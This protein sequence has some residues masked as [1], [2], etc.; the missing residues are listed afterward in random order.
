MINF[1]FSLANPWSNRWSILFFKN[2]L[3]PNHKAWEFNGYLT[4]HIVDVRF[5]LSFTGDHPGL[6][7]MLG[8]VGCSLEFSV[9]DTRHG[10]MR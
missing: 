1:D 2:G 5:S 3:L 7:I 10:D 8:L 6:F 4:H 9:Y